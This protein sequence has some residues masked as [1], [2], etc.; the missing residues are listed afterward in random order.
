MD[1][2]TGNR[3]RKCESE[4]GER[5]RIMRKWYSLRDKVYQMENLRKSFQAVKANKGAPGMDGETIEALEAKLS[6]NLQ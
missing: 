4:H 5:E 6:N 3:N 1:E 2:G